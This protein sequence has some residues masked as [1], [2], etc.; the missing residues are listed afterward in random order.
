MKKRDFKTISYKALSVLV[1]FSLLAGMFSAFPSVSS[2]V[3]S[4]SAASRENIFTE[5][6]DPYVVFDTE[7]M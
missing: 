1:V 5:G 2:P 3:L 6:V 4:A 7:Y